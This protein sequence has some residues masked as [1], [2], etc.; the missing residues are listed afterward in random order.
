MRILHKLILITLFGFSR[1]LFSQIKLD[2]ALV[3]LKGVYFFGPSQ[4]EL[5]SNDENYN[6]AYADFSY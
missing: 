4:N 3:N 6:E 5:D 1:L 2:T